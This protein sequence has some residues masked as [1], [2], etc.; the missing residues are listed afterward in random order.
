MERSKIL[1][2][3]MYG[4]II[5]E[6]KGFFIPY[7]YQRFDSISSSGSIFQGEDSKR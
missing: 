2:I 1:L 6:S 5:K 7:I 3:D 4:V